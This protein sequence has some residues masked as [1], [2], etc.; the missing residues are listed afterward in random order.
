MR[1][2]VVGVGVLSNLPSFLFKEPSSVLK[3]GVN[4]CQ[5]Y[6]VNEVLGLLVTQFVRNFSRKDAT[7]YQRGS[8]GSLLG[9]IQAVKFIRHTTSRIFRAPHCRG[10]PDARTRFNVLIHLKR[11]GAGACGALASTNKY[12]A[13]INKSLDWA[14]ATKRGSAQPASAG[15]IGPNRPLSSA[16]L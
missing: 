3:G 16:L 9:R 2:A 7:P 8:N 1:T 15:R 12:L 13:Q 5:R 6:L 14:K 4:V 10:S 11:F